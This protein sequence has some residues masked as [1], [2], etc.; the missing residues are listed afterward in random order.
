MDIN[1]TELGS[2][3]CASF[4]YIISRPISKYGRGYREHAPL[5]LA[6]RRRDSGRQRRSQLIER[7]SVRLNLLHLRIDCVECMPARIVET[8]MG[9]NFVCIVLSGVM[10]AAMATSAFAA[11]PKP[12]KMTFEHYFDRNVPGGSK[13]APHQQKPRQG[14]P[15]PRQGLPA[16]TKRSK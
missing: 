16:P 6:Q 5:C 7:S 15:A 9:D 8:P 2:W 11:Q 3:L 13:L 10:L 1:F 4:V 12:G 14:L